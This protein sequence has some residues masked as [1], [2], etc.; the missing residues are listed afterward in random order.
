MIWY[1]SNSQ[2][3]GIG[4]FMVKEYLE[5]MREVFVENKLTLKEQIYVCEN[6]IKENVQFI[7]V[8]EDTS[9]PNY[10]AFT[11]RHV[12]RFN[13]Q[14]ITELQE[15][16]KSLIEQVTEL[17]NQL[18]EIDCK[19]D[20]ITSV[21]KVVKED[22]SS[23]AMDETMKMTLLRTVETERQRIARDLHDST[24]QDL[25]SLLHK[26]E[27]C[28]K[29]LEV[30][31]PRCKME[32]LSMGKTLREV[33]EETRKMIYDLRPMAFDDVEFGVTIERFLDRFS[34]LNH[35]SCEFH[36]EG[37][38]CP[39]DHVVQIT[40]LRVIQEACNNSLHHAQAS[41]LDIDLIYEEERLTIRIVDDGRGFDMNTLAETSEEGFGMSTM[42]E[43]VYLLSGT[44]CIN[45]GEGDGC[46]IE[47][48]IP[49]SKED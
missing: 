21:I 47:V 44:L 45:S 22:A 38:P 36:V 48:V 2:R 41:R 9:D 5:N 16:Q 42:K 39:L 20:E 32:L 34:R 30:D 14:K 37:M 8:L 40:L 4:V 25:T 6:A 11:P 19:I 15:E 33:I 27:L 12:N 23:D 26:T 1:F 35:I 17:R 46:T 13:Q 10:E 18:G 49:V 7:G 43:R 3:I 28:S 24:T 29:L 31:P